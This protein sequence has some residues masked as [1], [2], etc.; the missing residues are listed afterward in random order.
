MGFSVEARLIDQ[1]A[2][3]PPKAPPALRRLKL[4]CPQKPGI[5]KT[6][7][8]LLK[9]NGCLMKEIDA[10]TSARG[11]EIWFEFECT[12]ECEDKTVRAR[13]APCATRCVSRLSCAP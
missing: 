9:D 4:S 8:E 2:T 6:I 12:V 3:K 5:I 13:P 11:G 10:N 1:A 7:S